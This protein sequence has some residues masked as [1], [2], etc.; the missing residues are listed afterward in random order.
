MSYGDVEHRLH[1]GGI[2]ILD[3]GTGTELE[4]RGVAMDPQAWCGSAALENIHIL[5]DIHRD[6]IAVGADIITTNTYCS[7]RIMLATAGYGDQ[8]EQINRN[9][10][11]A[12]MRAR[13]A[14]G[15]DD[16]LVAGSLSHRSPSISGTAQSDPAR[17][18]NA[19]QMADAFGEQAE[20][21]RDEG[22]DL[23]LLE[24]MYDPERMSF[25]FEAAKETGLPVWAGFSARHGADGQVM[26]FASDRA[27]PFAEVVGILN[28]HKVAAAG[29]MHTQA[30]VI[31]DALEILRQR[32][33]G[34]L[35]AY[36]DS[37]Y[38]ESPSWV[39]KDVIPPRELHR[40]AS[41]WTANGVQI[42]GG[43]CGLSPEHIAALKPLQS[44]LKS[45]SNRT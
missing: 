40:F 19:A 24:M 23:V 30:N 35:L 29:I 39:F 11:A 22:C 18:P 14:S 21:L 1:N 43:C 5:E 25:V 37:G 34:P 2:V 28:R 44:P 8:F 20:L 6:Y 38:F 36:P 4:R 31:G 17:A 26:G 41:E 3:G 9:T 42:I 32:F 45:S 27:I 33:A 10:V 16:V 13:K 7:S 15:R 12:A